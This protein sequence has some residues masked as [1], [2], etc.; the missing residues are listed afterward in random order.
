MARSIWFVVII[1]IYHLG[2]SLDVL[3]Q[4]SATKPTPIKK[5]E[6]YI[7]FPNDRIIGE[8]SCC[9]KIEESRGQPRQFS[10]VVHQPM[11][12]IGTSTSTWMKKKLAQ[13]MGEFV[14]SKAANAGA[15]PEE[16]TTCIDRT[17]F[18]PIPAIGCSIKKSFQLSSPL[19]PFFALDLTAFNTKIA[20]ILLPK[21]ASRLLWAVEKIRSNSLERASFLNWPDALVSSREL[22]IDTKAFLSITESLKKSA[23]PVYEMVGYPV[24][25]RLSDDASTRRL[26]AE[27][28]HSL[29]GT[30]PVIIFS[31]KGEKIELGFDGY[32]WKDSNRWGQYI[33]RPNPSF[34]AYYPDRTS[35][36]RSVF[37]PE[38]L[39]AD[40]TDDPPTPARV[41]SYDSQETVS[42]MLLDKNSGEYLN[43]IINDGDP[44][45]LKRF[46]DD[47]L[48][49]GL[50]KGNHIQ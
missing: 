48:N 25:I 9:I 30:A 2:Y 3:A 37:F 14:I 7:K 44:G 21:T 16:K 32:Q 39:P 17:T 1:M 26:V 6:T 41:K 24:T 22:P 5:P 38:K 23:P 13:E 46:I 18:W 35:T 10:I 50:S 43:T 47:Y 27:T 28:A 11:G 33:R 45:G 34:L 49:N 15:M 42:T 4:R 20:D 12:A 19:S 36:S 31:E 29:F 8:A 40:G